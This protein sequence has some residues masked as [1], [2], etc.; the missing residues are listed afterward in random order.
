M[1]R[2][3]AL[4]YCPP[5][6]TP[7]G[8]IVRRLLILALALALG[9]AALAADKDSSDTPKAA[10]TRTKLTS[11]RV[12]VEWKDTLLRDVLDELFKEKGGGV[13]IRTDRNAVVLNT[14]ITYKAKDKTIEEVLND[15]S[16]KYEMGWYITSQQNGSYDGAVWLEKSKA[17][18]YAPGKEPAKGETKPDPKK[19]PPKKEEPKKETPAE[20]GGDKLEKTANNALK[21]AQD[22]IKDGKV[23]KAREYLKNNVIKKYPKTKAAETAKELLEKLDK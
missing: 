15:L 9:G 19:E 22:L 3:T 20:D 4:L 23:D 6:R 7:G 16:E 10:A 17:R 5:P 8:S 2:T 13:G 18:G 21:F 14:K 11:T 12:E 1:A